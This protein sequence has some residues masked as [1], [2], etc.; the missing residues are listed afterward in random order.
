MQ[1]WTVKEE[2]FLK[3]WVHESNHFEKVGLPICGARL[4]FQTFHKLMFIAAI[5]LLILADTDSV[6]T[7]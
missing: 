3:T 2:G 7:K 1:D 4:T 6:R 5:I